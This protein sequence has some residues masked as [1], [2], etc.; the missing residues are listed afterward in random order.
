MSADYLDMPAHSLQKLLDRIE[1][2]SP[3]VPLHTLCVLAAET[4]WGREYKFTPGKMRLRILA[5]KLRTLCPVPEKISLKN[6]GQRLTGGV[7]RPFCISYGMGVDST[8][9]IVHLV[10]MYRQTGK[11]EYRP[12]C[13]TFADTGN[14]K[15]ETYAYLPVINAYLRANGFPEV[16]VVRYKP[17]R[18]KVGMYYTLE[19]NCLMNGTLPSLAFGYK[20]CSL[21]WKVGPQDEY[22]ATLPVC[23]RAWAAGHVGIVAIG[24]D[25]GP[26]DSCRAWDI[27]ANEFYEYIYPLMELGWDRHKC[28]SEI[29]NEGLPGWETDMGGKWVESGGVP[30]KSAC[31]FCPSLQPEEVIAYSKTEHGREYLRAIIRMEANAAPKLTQIEGLWRNGVKGTRGGKAKPGRISAFIRAQGLLGDDKI[32]LPVL[33]HYVFD[34]PEVVAGTR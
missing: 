19:Q 9:M 11:A 14:E 6:L 2:Q 13:I 4:V 34:G 26:K 16:V 20:K 28:I 25:A 7:R 24:Y 32:S 5:D 12:D 18:V 21:K 27:Q 15:K 22:R 30:V 29:R 3:G 10:R 33:Q 17:G 23:Q 31:W 1:A 8:A